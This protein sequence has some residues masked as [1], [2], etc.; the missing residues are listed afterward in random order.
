MLPRAP[1][2]A[3]LLYAGVCAGAC[4]LAACSMSGT[5]DPAG[6]VGFGGAQDIGQFRDL[7]ELGQIPQPTTFDANGFFAEHY[8]EQPP[9]TCADP[10]C[11]SAM[12]A[13]GRD[14]VTGQPHTALQVALVSTIDPKTLPDRPLDLVFVVDRS[15]SM[16][17]D[18]RLIKVQ[19][20]LR[21]LV[22]SLG[23]EDRLGLVSF[24][25][26]ARVE[27]RLGSSPAE[28]RAAINNLSPDGGT[29]LF[30]GLSLGMQMAATGGEE[31]ERR[32]ILLSD[33]LAT[34]GETRDSAII[35][36]AE[37]FVQEGGGALHHRRG[38]LLQ[39]RAHALAGR[40]RRR[41]LLLRRRR[42][43]GAGGLHR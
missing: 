5:S 8:V 16:S 40:A 20:G 10:L 17:A 38:P 9:A 15:G 7:V 30:D 18:D 3:P 33:G 29:N 26:S 42:P 25:S 24:E 32:V 36:V 27:A 13:R 2:F 31:R 28:L 11:L 39:S 23:P 41:Q 14:W 35:G 43:G 1:S 34:S 12:L 6:G 19:S 22:D 37:R 21:L 4:A